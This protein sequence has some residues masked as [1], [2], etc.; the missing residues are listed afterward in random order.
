[1]Q[2]TD[3]EQ[4][5]KFLTLKEVCGLLSV[6]KTTIYYLMAG[7]SGDAERFPRPIKFG[8]SSRW[9]YS[10]VMAWARSRRLGKSLGSA[11]KF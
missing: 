5:E 1:M 3:H 10:D 2:K 8:R 9:L 6:G 4:A 11:S 7:S